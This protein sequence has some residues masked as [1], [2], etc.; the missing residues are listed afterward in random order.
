M[1]YHIDEIYYS[2]E[3]KALYGALYNENNELVI[4]ATLEY[5][6][7]QIRSRK[8]DVKNIEITEKRI[9]FAPNYE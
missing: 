3:R 1:K 9:T 5:I 4:S 8:L 2:L 6:F 7:E